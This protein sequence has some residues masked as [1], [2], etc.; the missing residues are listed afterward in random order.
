M[1][2]VKYCGMALKGISFIHQKKLF[3]EVNFNECLYP[4]KRESNLFPLFLHSQSFTLD[5]HEQDKV[6]QKIF[7]Q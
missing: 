5:V 3:Y 7:L 6:I 2:D 4:R 1:K